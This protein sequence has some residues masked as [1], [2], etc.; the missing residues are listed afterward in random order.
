MPCALRCNSIY[1][2]L[3]Y[4]HTIT[5]TIEV[6]LLETEKMLSHACTCAL[7]GLR[8]R[9]K[10]TSFGKSCLIVATISHEIMTNAKR[11]STYSKPLALGGY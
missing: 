10:F 2:Y 4:N 6:S 3:S 7:G 11:N 1:S 8:L 9:S 5:L